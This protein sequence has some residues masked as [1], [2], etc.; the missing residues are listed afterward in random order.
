[1]MVLLTPQKGCV[2]L[3]TNSFSLPEVNLLIKTLNEKW[4]LKCTINKQGNAFVI[5]IPPKSLPIL[6]SL[7][8]DIIPAMMKH[9]IGL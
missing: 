2:Y 8:K 9:K 1:M 7:L 3:C 5:K 6:Q 4:D